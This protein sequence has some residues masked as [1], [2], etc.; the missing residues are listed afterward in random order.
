ME[1]AFGFYIA[2]KLAA[3]DAEGHKELLLRLGALNDAIGHHF[4]KHAY[5]GALGMDRR[6]AVELIGT[7]LADERF[8]SSAI[9]RI[10]DRSRKLLATAV[11]PQPEADARNL[12]SSFSWD[13]ANSKTV[14]QQMTRLI[15]DCALE[16][17]SATGVGSIVHAPTPWHAWAFL[18]ARNRDSLL[19]VE[20]GPQSP[21]FYRGQPNCNWDL[22]ASIHRPN[23]DIEEETQAAQAF[24]SLIGHHLIRNWTARCY[25][26][27]QPL[28]VFTEQERIPPELHLAT[29]QHYGLRTPLLDFTTD[30]DVAIWFAC[31]KPTG[32]DC[33]ASV[34]AF[35]S[36]RPQARII[37][38]H[39]YV[40]R[41]Y[42]QRGVFI[43]S[44]TLTQAEL[45]KSCTE[46]RFRPNAE[47]A[48]LRS[49][50]EVD[51][52]GESHDVLVGDS[53]YWWLHQVKVART[54]VREGRLQDL[55]S[56]PTGSL[57]ASQMGLARLL[58]DLD[59]DLFPPLDGSLI[60]RSA[61]DLLDV[62]LAFGTHGSDKGFTV[63]DQSL[64]I[65][66]ENGEFSIR[67][68]LPI[69]RSY[70]MELPRNQKRSD[71]ESLLAA[72]ETQIPS[73]LNMKSAA[74]PKGP[75]QPEYIVRSPLFVLQRQLEGAA[76]MLRSFAPTK[77]K[78]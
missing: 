31:Q 25:Q 64:R 4:G 44:R 61:A 6:P 59:D 42:R 69:L 54:I 62:L 14:W 3:L 17:S 70:L 13:R 21:L 26:E 63:S 39:P 12:Y 30:P 52:L 73:W 32:D 1:L 22:V 58:G 60:I 24:A 19:G 40:R 8:V 10:P 48:V 68:M 71:V 50:I 53:D 47:F 49:G 51:L 41:L 37:F 43:D 78:K 75:F 23:V 35:S 18:V 55:L 67:L 46:V 65:L 20:G 27:P 76:E 15:H 7:T 38:P 33:E 2:L 72:I 34:F 74:L 29:A 28:I 77:R 57:E 9:R 56:L 66:K 5:Y 16:P 11:N 45:K 36:A